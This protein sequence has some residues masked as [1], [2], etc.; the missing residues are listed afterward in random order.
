M[1]MYMVIWY[2]EWHHYL[3]LEEQAVELLTAK[4]N[5]VA[6]VPVTDNTHVLWL[7]VYAIRCEHI[8]A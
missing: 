4:V 7:A 1:M 6:D 3:Q 2:G 8:S 5:P